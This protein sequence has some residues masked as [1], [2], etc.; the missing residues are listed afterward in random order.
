MDYYKKRVVTILPLYYFC[1]VWY[2]ITESLLDYLNLLEIP[3]DIYHLRWFRYIFLLNGVVDS[4]CYFWRNLGI[5]WSIP[6]FAFFYL[7]AP[8]I[9]EGITSIK[10][11]FIVWGIVW[12]VSLIIEYCLYNY[13]HYNSTIVK[14][15]HVFLFGSMLFWIVKA[16][17]TCMSSLLFNI[18]T[19]PLIVIKQYAE[20]YLLLFSSI[21]ILCVSL[22]KSFKIG[23][24]I[25]SVISCIDKYSYSL[26]LMHGIVFCSFI[27]RIKNHAPHWLVGIIAIIGTIIA[28]WT[29]YNY[30]EL[31]LKKKFKAILGLSA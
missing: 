21:T 10:K 2:F 9:L 15:L 20:V 6:V 23:T 24:K 25:E 7:I 4:N 1:I 29:G 3:E 26:Y 5:T 17:M 13:F 19:I 8:I 30:I 14:N 31:P 22:E 28:T 18:L 16:D 12:I 27:D 11:S